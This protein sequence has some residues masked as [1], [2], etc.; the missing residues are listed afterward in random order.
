M[1][2]GK[3]KNTRKSAGMEVL[4]TP[5]KKAA[6][7]KGAKVGLTT[8]SPTPTP[9]A[10]TKGTLAAIPKLFDFT[11]GVD[12]EGYETVESDSVSDST[13]SVVSAIFAVGGDSGGKEKEKEDSDD[14]SDDGS[15]FLGETMTEGWQEMAAL[16][17]KMTDAEEG[18]IVGFLLSVVSNACR[19]EPTQ[20]VRLCCGLG[21]DCV[22]L[23][24]DKIEMEARE[25]CSF[26]D[27]HAIMKS[28]LDNKRQEVGDLEEDVKELKKTVTKL[29]GEVR[30]Q[31][32]MREEDR[33][34][35]G[36]KREGFMGP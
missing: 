14:R 11:L 2:K 6:G 30:F 23:G 19:M 16:C 20:V 17:G 9:V 4:S 25:V 36:T 29:E 27:S 28:E 33:K 18:R 5:E 21:D 10:A 26:A 24:M 12:V 22:A 3:N 8:P 7:I 13:S 32:R 31:R 35:S 1:P 15:R 34:K